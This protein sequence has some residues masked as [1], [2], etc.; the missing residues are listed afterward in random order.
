MSTFE[1]DLLWVDFEAKKA[2]FTDGKLYA[3]EAL[4]DCMAE[5]TDDPDEALVASVQVG[6]D[7]YV[8]VSLVAV[9]TKSTLN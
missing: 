7:L 4:Y 3:I 9:V 6:D 1:P 5:E 2:M 8:V